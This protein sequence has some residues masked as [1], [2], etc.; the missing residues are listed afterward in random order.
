MRMAVLTVKFLATPLTMFGAQPMKLTLLGGSQL[1]LLISLDA[2]VCCCIRVSSLSC[3]SDLE[4]VL[5]TR[6][7]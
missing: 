5:E 4:R 3:N 1:T 6:K 2:A 7:R